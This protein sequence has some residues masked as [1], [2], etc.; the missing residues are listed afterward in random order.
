MSKE[1][2]IEV[3]PKDIL[4]GDLILDEEVQIFKEALNTEPFPTGMLIIYPHGVVG[5]IGNAC[6]AT[7]KRKLI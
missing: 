7:I 1:I 5:F 4:K 2:V 6:K 3:E